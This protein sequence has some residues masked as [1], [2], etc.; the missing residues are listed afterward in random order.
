MRSALA[1]SRTRIAAS[2]ASATMGGGDPT[3]DLHEDERYDAE[4]DDVQLGGGDC[5]VDCDDDSKG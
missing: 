1:A 3:G 5:G 2:R 4:D